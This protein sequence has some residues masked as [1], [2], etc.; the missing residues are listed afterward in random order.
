VKVKFP[1]RLKESKLRKKTFFL[2]KDEENSITS[3][4]SSSSGEAGQLA[5]EHRV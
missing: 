4:S 5:P 3:L 1:K 2:I